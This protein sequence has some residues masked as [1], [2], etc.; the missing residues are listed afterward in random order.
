MKMIFEKEVFFFAMVLT[1]PKFLEKPKCGTQ[2]EK[3]KK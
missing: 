3:A 2:N 1:H